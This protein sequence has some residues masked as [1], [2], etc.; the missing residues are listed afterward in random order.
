MY[1]ILGL[2]ALPFLLFEKVQYR[3]ILITFPALA[4]I[5]C[6]ITII[7]MK[8]E[9]LR[10]E[11]S[12]NRLLSLQRKKGATSLFENLDI[13]KILE[14][15]KKAKKVEGNKKEKKI[16]CFD[17]ML[18]IPVRKKTGLLYIILIIAS[19]FEIALIALDK[20]FR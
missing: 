3:Y 8:T 11:A 17:E 10:M 12:K 4:I 2:I 9:D 14:D 15:R 7:L 6:I 13:D 1:A 20:L 19:I 5:F 18:K 16:R